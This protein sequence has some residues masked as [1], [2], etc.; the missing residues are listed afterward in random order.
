MG[1][2]YIFENDHSFPLIHTTNSAR[3]AGG[4]R[5][6]LGITSNAE[7]SRTELARQSESEHEDEARCE[8]G[9]GQI[10]PAIL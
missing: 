2:D 3:L 9:A 1:A 5:L 4:A 10:I 8:A 6:K 7:L